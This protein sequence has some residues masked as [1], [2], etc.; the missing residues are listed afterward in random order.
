MRAGTLVTHQIAGFGLACALA[1]QRIAVEAPRVAG[2]RDALWQGLRDLPGAVLN[3]HPES[4]APGILNV[5]FAGVEGESLFSG[6]HEIAVSTGSACSSRSGEPSYVLRALG[7]DT[8]QAQGSLRFSLGW[9]SSGEDVATAVEAVRR[10]HASLWNASPARGTPVG[11]WELAGNGQILVGEAG[12]ERL[13]TW[14]RLA[15]WA[16]QGVIRDVRMQVYGC[17]HTAA[18]CRLVAAEL[19]CSPLTRLP[20]GDPENWRKSVH[21]PV[22]K[23]GQMLIIGDALT[24]LCRSAV[25]ED[26]IAPPWPSP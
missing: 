1:M 10:V 25:P 8:A 7:R 26:P 12:A 11:D 15:A 6:L 9:G 5:T 20:S 14:V 4:R 16:Q 21:A 24:A 22:E 17:L 23:L 18:A 2:L 19:R 3:G 13:G